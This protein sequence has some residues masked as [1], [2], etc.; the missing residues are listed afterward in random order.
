MTKMADL[1]NKTSIFSNIW[2]F[3]ERYFTENN[4]NLV[5][6]SFLACS[7]QFQFLSQGDHFAK[8]TA[9]S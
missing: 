8:D 6:G 7:W 3:L 2:S 4:S 1:K 5:V 9:S